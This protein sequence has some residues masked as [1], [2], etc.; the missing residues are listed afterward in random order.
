MNYVT[1]P[2]SKLVVEFAW[3][4]Q[5]ITGAGFLDLRG[6]L[7]FVAP[8]SLVL[9]VL[10][11]QPDSLWE[12]AAWVV[13]NLMAFL[14]LA[15]LVALRKWLLIRAIDIQI[16]IALATSAL[17]GSAKAV[18]T[19]GLAQMF[20][21]GEFR[22]TLFQAGLGA[23]AGLLAIP[24]TA[25]MVET[26]TQY[27]KDRDFL[28][29]RAFYLELRTFTSKS[30]SIH[31]GVLRK[32]IRELVRR[33]E[34]LDPEHK[35]EGS[36]LALLQELVDKRLR[37]LSHSLYT[38]LEK[39]YPGFDL[40][41]ILKTAVNSVPPANTL[42]LVYL[43]SVGHFI[44]Q[45][46]LQSGL[47]L[48]A[49]SAL[50]LFCMNL[51][52]GK[53]NRLP[54]FLRPIVFLAWGCLSAGV[55]VLVSLLSLGLDPM[56]H[57]Y[58]ICMAAFWN[59]HSTLLFSAIRQ[60]RFR[61]QLNKI[62]LMKLGQTTDKSVDGAMHAER[63]ELANQLHGE[64]QSRMLRLTLQSEAGKSLRREIV[65]G[66]LRAIEKLLGV[67]KQPSSSKLQV[68]LKQLISQWAGLAEVTVCLEGELVDSLTNPVVLA[69]EQVIINS[70][71]HG[72]A[73]KIQIKVA[74]AAQ[75]FATVLVNDNGV[76]PSNGPRGTGS[77]LFDSVFVEWALVA[78]P[79]GGA[80]F[81]ASLKTV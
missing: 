40:P 71:R 66:E 1:N 50:L 54:T 63:R 11:A 72:L 10:S 69:L 75:G 62:E 64:V 76:G 26:W 28:I 3:F 61:A 32:Q 49:V 14:C 18:V 39:R 56:D 53:S 47:A 23:I 60:A 33:I 25:V 44:S 30:E 42:S 7:L 21:S 29:E 78:N 20:M 8:V 31:L 17:A 16:S 57:L 46:G 81:R 43:F 13:A 36:Q 34:A 80:E 77:L 19:A 67:R 73:D 52:L 9:S 74:S 37:P 59:L 41:E 4:R 38:G 79:S 22:W 35:I 70:F 5:A 27:Q 45:F 24:A 48:L 65:L 6:L 58:T 12:T 51:V 55:A 15:P 2:A 68:Q